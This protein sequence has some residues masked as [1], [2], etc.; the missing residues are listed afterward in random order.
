MLQ[1]TDQN[2]NQIL[3]W[4]ANRDDNYFCPGCKEQVVYKSGVI[5]CAHFAHRPNSLCSFAT[6]EGAR[7]EEMKYQISRYIKEPMQ[8]S[9]EVPFGKEHRADMVITS[10][11]DRLVV[12]CQASAISIPN[13][14]ERNRYYNSKG[15]PV[16][17]V[18]DLDRVGVEDSRIPAEIR[19]CHYKSFGKVYVLNPEGSLLACHL[20]YRTMTI[21]YKNFIKPPF[22]VTSF[23]TKENFKLA[24]LGEGIFW[25][26]RKQSQ[27]KIDDYNRQAAEN[28]R[29]RLS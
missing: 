2:Q 1:A 21:A 29:K 17:W 7:H 8:V 9:L 28:N 4:E 10:G 23:Q 27:Q 14:E 18:W 20:R 15:Y 11:R 3:S 19:N 16:L 26:T 22:Q 6:G 12:E 25:T 5:V 24:Q 13:W